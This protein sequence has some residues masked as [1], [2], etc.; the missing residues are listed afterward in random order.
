MLHVVASEDLEVGLAV[1]QEPFYVIVG[2]FEVFGFFQEQRFYLAHGQ[3][4]FNVVGA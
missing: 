4:S 2:T 3:R 1:P